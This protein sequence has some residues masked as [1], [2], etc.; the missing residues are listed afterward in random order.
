LEVAQK[1]RVSVLVVL[2]FSQIED[3]VLGKQGMKEGLRAG[4][5]IIV[6]STIA[7]S[8]I[9]NLGE[10]LEAHGAQVLDAPISGGKKGPRPGLF[11]SW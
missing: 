8:Q 10:K 6:S 2:N 4:D 11:P 3:V 1:A 5:M 9:R 7:P